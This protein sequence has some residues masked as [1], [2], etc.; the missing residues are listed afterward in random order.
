MGH[1][2]IQLH[3]QDNPSFK[4]E[5]SKDGAMAANLWDVLSR[6]S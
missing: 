6:V 3:A 1:G 2:F 5:M 4:R